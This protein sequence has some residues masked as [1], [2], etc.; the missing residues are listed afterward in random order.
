MISGT[1]TP[2]SPRSLKSLDAS[3]RILPWRAA[4]TS[5][6]YRTLLPHN[7]LTLSMTFI[8]LQIKHDCHHA[9]AEQG[10]PNMRAVHLTAYGNP[11]DGIEFVEIPEPP[12]PSANQVLV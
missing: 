8:M 2:L 10:E 5:A 12:E 1:L 7:V 6:G 4:V 3:C 9:S 11:I